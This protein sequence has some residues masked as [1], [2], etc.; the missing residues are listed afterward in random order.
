MLWNVCVLSLFMYFVSA[1]TRNPSKFLVYMQ[2]FA[3]VYRVHV[4]FRLLYATDIYVL[5]QH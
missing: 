1:R 4:V 3:T 5:E 2:L